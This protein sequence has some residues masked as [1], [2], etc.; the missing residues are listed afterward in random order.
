M[1]TIDDVVL[2]DVSNDID[3]KNIDSEE[4][5]GPVPQPGTR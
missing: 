3:D 5:V 2:P 1:K 4:K